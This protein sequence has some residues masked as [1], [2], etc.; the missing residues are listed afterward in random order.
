MPTFSPF[1]TFLPY[2]KAV[3]ALRLRPNGS[4]IRPQL[5]SNYGLIGKQDDFKYGKK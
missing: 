2:N 4:A 1:H 3:I 5:R